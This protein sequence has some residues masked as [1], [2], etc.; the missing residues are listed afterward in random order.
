VLVGPADVRGEYLE[1]NAM[2]YLAALW[3][4]KPWVRNSFNGDPARTFV[5]DA[6]ISHGDL[7]HYVT[8]RMEK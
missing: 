3:S 5:N 1:D 4:F 6:S 7:L 8:R 2:R